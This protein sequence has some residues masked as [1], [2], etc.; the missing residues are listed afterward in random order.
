MIAAFVRYKRCVGGRD[1]VSWL[2]KRVQMLSDDQTG[3]YLHRLGMKEIPPASLTALGELQEQH[4]LHVPFEN[5]DIHLGVPIRLDVERIF[6][7]VV[8]RSRGGF[9]YELNSLFGELLATTGFEVKM[10]SARVYDPAR[11]V[12]SPEYDHL[13]LVV[14]VEDDYLVD[15]G[16]GDFALRPLRIIPGSQQDQYGTFNITRRDV[17][18]YCVARQVGNAWVDQYLFSLEGRHL[19]AFTDRCHYH[20]TSPESHFRQKSLCS[21]ATK[22]GRITVT[23]DK[24][25]ITRSGDVTET[26]L[27]SHAAFLSALERYCG[28]RL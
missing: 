3:R 2:D 6:E 16:F 15:V 4:L 21:I 22:E 28:V 9:C 27:H 25:K 17:G 13:A 20:Q 1:T 8:D 14:T 5:L 23:P 7:K 26:A 11:R 18:N 10:V 12:Y 19:G 24:I